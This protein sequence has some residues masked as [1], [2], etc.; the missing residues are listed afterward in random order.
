MIDKLHGSSMLRKSRYAVSTLAVMLGLFSTAVRLDA[1]APTLDSLVAS[2]SSLI[3]GTAT[4]V[5]ISVSVSK[6]T[7]AVDDVSLLEADA[8][9]KRLRTLAVM[10]D[11]GRNGDAVVG[12]RRYSTALTLN[13]TGTGA[14]YL[15]ASA[16]LKGAPGRIAS[17]LLLIPVASNAGAAVFGPATFNRGNGAPVP[18]K[19]T[20]RVDRPT[21]TYTLR[22]TNHGVTSGV[23]SLNGQIVVRP[24]DFTKKDR[25]RDDRD[26]GDQD[27]REDD[28]RG[29]AGGDDDAVA[30]IQRTV[31]LRA[32]INEIIVEL[33]GK[34]GTSLELE[35]DGSVPTTALRASPGGP[36]A[37]KVGQ[38]MTF[39]G[40]HSR[41]PSGRTITSFAWNFGDN[42]SGSGATPS[43]IYATAG[44]YQV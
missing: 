22:I 16:T 4:V 44:T 35:I 6:G 10:H 5:T 30:S 20:F 31:T 1:A 9:G 37:G 41:V 23:I 13:P 2:P 28:N 39:D 38:A 42:S 25:D 15:Q 14:I 18:V 26:L 3:V 33:Q 24:D 43:H 29:G 17:S 7:P 36:Y 8:S 21:G 40:S 11:D 12:D 27:R 19:R 34:P 32:G